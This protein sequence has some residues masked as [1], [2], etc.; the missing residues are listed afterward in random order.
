M[1][2][3]EFTDEKIKLSFNTASHLS[4]SLHGR[5]SEITLQLVFSASF[6]FGDED[7]EKLSA[8]RKRRNAFEM[9]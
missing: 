5:K 6:P 1:K 9:R 4:T 3:D 2:S 7:D 8:E